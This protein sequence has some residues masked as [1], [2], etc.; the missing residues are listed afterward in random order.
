MEIIK[1]KSIKEFKRIFES[2]N[3]LRVDYY[4]GQAAYSWDIIPG[5]SRNKG[6]K[7]IQ[8]LLEIERKLIDNFQKKINEN[9][10]EDLIPK[11]TGSYHERWILLMAAQHYGLPTRLID[12]SHDKF[13][14]L[15]FAV[16]DFLHLNKDG[17][18]II[19]KNAN[20]IQKDLRSE[21]LISPFKDSY[22][23][24]FFQVPILKREKNNECL[25]SESRKSIQGS[26][27][28]YRD[29]EN[30]HKCLSLEGTHRN[31]LVIIHI[32][33]KLK[34]LLIKYLIEIGKMTYDLYKGKNELDYHSAILKNEFFALNDS[35]I[36][37]YLKS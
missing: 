7:D 15:E 32:P 28:L 10:L 24:F 29:S 36:S 26:K 9:K 13:A 6:I 19:Y 30:L 2:Y 27:F 23:S 22:Q 17:A 35:K 33:A 8:L 21:E 1:P 34:I 18:L 37:E 16:A 31:N 11:I 14:A 20:D 3:N 25:L 5:I 12:F 4:R